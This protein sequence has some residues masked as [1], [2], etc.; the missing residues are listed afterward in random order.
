MSKADCSSSEIV[1]T[2]SIDDGIDMELNPS[3]L[4]GAVTAT[5]FPLSAMDPIMLHEP[6][7]IA[8]KAK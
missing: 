1:Y 3:T 8:A 2:T 4:M 6:R 5:P 7:T